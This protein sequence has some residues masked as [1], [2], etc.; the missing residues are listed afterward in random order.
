VTDMVNSPPHYLQHP[1]GLECIEITRL[2]PFT[3]GNA[4]KYLWRMTHKNGVEDARKARWYL[5]D[6]LSHGMASHPPHK[7]KGLL[8]AAVAADTNPWRQQ[9]L[10]DIAHGHLEEAI[11]MIDALVGDDA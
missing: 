2:M 9:L 6:H 1:S 10:D 7:A 4:V 8:E 11:E 3:T 5:M